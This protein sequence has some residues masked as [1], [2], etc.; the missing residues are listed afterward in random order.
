M[1]L[2]APHS[3][4]GRASSASPARSAPHATTAL[5]ASRLAREVHAGQ[6]D[7]YGEPVVEHVARVA[8]R[9]PAAA[10]PVAL[11]HDVPARSH[12]DP[13]EVACSVGLDADEQDAVAL[14][15]PVPGEDDVDH[16]ARIAAAAP[17]RGRDLAVAVKRADVADHTDRAPLCQTSTHAR[18]AAVLDALVG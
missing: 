7:R 11:V 13:A 9:V 4:D 12:L 16:A 6:I 2:S 3:T 5:R 8:A 18:A 15:V 14:L 1:A 10:R 17:G